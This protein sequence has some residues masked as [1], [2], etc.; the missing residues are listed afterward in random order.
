MKQKKWGDPLLLSWNCKWAEMNTCFSTSL[1]RRLLQTFW[2]VRFTFC[3]VCGCYF[4]SVS[5]GR[6]TPWFFPLVHTYSGYTNA[7]AHTH[8]DHVAFNHS[9]R[10]FWC[11]STDNLGFWFAV[12]SSHSTSS[13][14]HL[15]FVC[16]DQRLFLSCFLAFVELLLSLG[17][18]AGKIFT[19]WTKKLKDRRKGISIFLLWMKEE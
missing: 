19:I 16:F 8:T 10:S 5:W 1:K 17:L 18:S 7:C 12:L 11:L 14:I 6:C 15:S 3:L 4:K 9:T 13:T 2:N